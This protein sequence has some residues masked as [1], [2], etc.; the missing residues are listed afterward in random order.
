MGFMTGIAPCI[1]C[2]RPFAFNP[3]TVPS[4][5]AITG[6]REP[7]CRSCFDEI[8]R[9]RVAAGGDPFPVAPD[10]YEGIEVD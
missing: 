9:R 2:A 3:Y 10:A 1:C 7:I 8:N 6:H 4:T 5:S